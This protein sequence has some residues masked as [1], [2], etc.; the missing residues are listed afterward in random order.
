MLDKKA[1]DQGWN[2]ASSAQKIW[3]F[4]IT[5]NGDPSTI[6]ITKEHHYIEMAALRAQCKRFMIGE[7][8]QHRAHQNNQMLQAYIWELLTRRAQQRLAQ[9]KDEYTFNGLCCGP[10]LL[11]IIRHTVT[12]NAN[13]PT[14][15]A[16]APETPI[17]EGI[18][19]SKVPQ[20]SHRGRIKTI[21][22]NMI[23][24]AL[25]FTAHICYREKSSTQRCPAL[26]LTTKTKFLN[27]ITSKL[28]STHPFS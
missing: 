5:H 25:A 17:G 20:S 18:G 13:W 21:S 24:I 10:L 2:Y 9:Y 7:D 27:H 23:T 8:S 1:T 4:N 14:L 19:Q 11:N 15:T 6:S 16:Q 26:R 28:P 12:G 22:A 3:L